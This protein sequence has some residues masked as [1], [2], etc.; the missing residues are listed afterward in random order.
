M[1]G[2]Q[3]FKNRIIIYSSNPLLG[4]LPKEL[5]SRFFSFLLEYIHCTGGIH[6]ENSE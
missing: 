5:K 4:I 1:A 2:P 3:K 6:C